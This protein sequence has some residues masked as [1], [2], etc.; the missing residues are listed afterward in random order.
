MTNK[1]LALWFAEP[2]HKNL[3]GTRCVKYLNT[4]WSL[5]GCEPVSL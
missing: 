5:R 4:V 3:N 1:R 2:A